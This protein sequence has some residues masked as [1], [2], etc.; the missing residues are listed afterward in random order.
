MAEYL[1]AEV[2]ETHGLTTPLTWIEH[3]P[4][5]SG[6]PGEYSLVRF[7]SWRLEEVCLGGAWRWRVGSPNWSPSGP[8]EVEELIKQHMRSLCPF[9]HEGAKTA[10]SPEVKSDEV[11]THF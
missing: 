4:K 8:E 11:P 3:Y 1:A 6:K 9:F 10:R 2:I 5:H 7:S